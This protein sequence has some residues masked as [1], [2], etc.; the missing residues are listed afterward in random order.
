MEIDY[1]LIYILKLFYIFLNTFTLYNLCQK[2]I[3]E[4]K[5]KENEQQ[6]PRQAE[7]ATKWQNVQCKLKI[8]C[9]NFNKLLKF[10]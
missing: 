1:I 4:M 3:R 2:I 8:N 10:N 9:N 6:Q 7:T 5:C